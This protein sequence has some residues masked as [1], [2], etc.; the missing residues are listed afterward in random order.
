MAH[1]AWPWLATLLTQVLMLASDQGP[2]KSGNA[3]LFLWLG[4]TQPAL[5]LATEVLLPTALPVLNFVKTW[6]YSGEQAKTPRGRCRE[7]RAG[8]SPPP[9][10]QA[11]ELGYSQA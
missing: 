8:T 9:W 4:A 1:T 2:Q 5:Q 3:A 10:G 11:T 6:H 7:G